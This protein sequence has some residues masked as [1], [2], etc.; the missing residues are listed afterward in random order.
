M[1]IERNVGELKRAGANFRQI[2]NGNDEILDDSLDILLS[3]VLDSPRREIENLI[4][5]LKALHNQLET[6]RSLIHRDI[7][8]YADQSQQVIQLT[9]IISDG[10]ENLPRAPRI[11]Q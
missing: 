3:R 11:S 10:V 4:A 1:D 5:D 7:V 8:E 9:A 6:N 2:E